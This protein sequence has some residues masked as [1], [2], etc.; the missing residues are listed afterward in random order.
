MTHSCGN[1]CRSH[2]R[3]LGFLS[4]GQCSSSL[5]NQI[6]AVLW[7]EGAERARRSHESRHARV[8]ALLGASSSVSY[9]LTGVRSGFLLC[10][11]L[12]VYFLSLMNL[13]P[14]VTE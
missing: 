6:V 5:G 11:F 1:K 9:T 10:V 3:A 12:T 2:L 7:N 4:A 13:K 14:R 8:L